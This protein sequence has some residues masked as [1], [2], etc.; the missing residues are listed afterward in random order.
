MCKMGMRDNL[1]PRLLEELTLDTGQFGALYAGATLTGRRA[2]R[3][4]LA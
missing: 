2:S 4:L 3:S 1:V